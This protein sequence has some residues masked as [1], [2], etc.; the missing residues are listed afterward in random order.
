MQGFDLE[1][2]IDFMYYLSIKAKTDHVF[3]IYEYLKERDYDFSA[4]MEILFR[5][6]NQSKETL[7]NNTTRKDFEHVV[8]NNPIFEKF[9]NLFIIISA[10]IVDVNP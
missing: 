1:S 8:L 5:Q 10:K 9:M 7:F 2:H 6:E 4:Q 3:S